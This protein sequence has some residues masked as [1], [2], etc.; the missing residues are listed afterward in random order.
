MTNALSVLSPYTYPP[1]TYRAL[2]RNI[3][4]GFIFRAVERFVGEF[5]AN[6]IFSP[7]GIPTDNA[8][9]AMNKSP[10]VILAG[11]NQLNDNFAP[12]PG[13]KAEEIRRGA[14][15]F[16]PMG[17]GL[18]GRGGGGVDLTQDALDILEIIHDR[19]EYSSWRCPRTVAI[20]EKALP[21]RRHQFLMT[22][23]PV[24]LD[25]PLLE[26]SSF[27]DNADR[28]AVT[29]TDRGDF[30]EREVPMLIRIAERFKTS[31]RYLVLQQDYAPIIA[32]RLHLD[33]LGLPRSLAGDR[34]AI[35][36]LARNLGYEI[37]RP[38]S[39]DAG[40]RFYREQA[41]LHFGSRLHAHLL[42]LSL[43]RKS[44]LVAVDERM[45]GFSEY[46]KF[47]LCD[48]QAID[49]HLD[50]DFEIVRAQARAAY[51]TMSK[52]VQ[53]IGEKSASVRTAASAKVSS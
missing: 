50:F 26:G 47:P 45:N 21:H 5:S 30:W 17:I 40:I 2:R 39:N 1:F 46:L 27:Q 12:W 13:L 32:T 36:Q 19:I 49:A 38:E 6:V 34:L 33:R 31:K 51:Q 4:D 7:R 16:I 25:K 52:F 35:R 28:I 42:M 24:V 44:F 22:C 15:R 37:V 53:S 9:S 11:A 43:N 23:C 20:L 18:G 3:G 8:K 29:I 14:Y 41:D 48:P 10:G